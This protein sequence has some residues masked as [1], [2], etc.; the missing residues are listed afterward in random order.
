MKRVII[1]VFVMAG[2]V[3]GGCTN[4]KALN[5]SDVA[6]DPAAFAGTITVTGIMAGVSQQDPA[7][8]GIMDVKELLCTSPN[9]NRVYLPVRHQGPMPVRGDEVLVTGNFTNSGRDYLFNATKVKVLK[10]HRIGG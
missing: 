4:N 6:S 5:V 2:M 10:N 7:V 9:C 1:I 3:L 8:F